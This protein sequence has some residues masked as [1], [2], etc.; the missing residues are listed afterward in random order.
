MPD[1]R[2]SEDEL[3]PLLQTNPKR[4]KATTRKLLLTPTD[5]DWF[6]E[7]YIQRVG[8]FYKCLVCPK[9]DSPNEWKTRANM[10]QHQ[11]SIMHNKNLEKAKTLK[12]AEQTSPRLVLYYPTVSPYE[13][14]ENATPVYFDLRCLDYPESSR[15]GS[16][17]ASSPESVLQSS[18]ENDYGVLE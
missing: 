1:R 9:S 16:V 3:P 14:V 6:S 4:G 11:N 10:G 13:P 2:T 15:R 17:T 8:Y 18:G 12:L 5:E 7:E